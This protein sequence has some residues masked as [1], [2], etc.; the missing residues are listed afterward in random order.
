MVN[1]PLFCI[2]TPSPF[3]SVS[4]LNRSMI[5]S[6]DHCEHIGF[7]D[8]G[9]WE[10]PQWPPFTRCHSRHLDPEWITSR[11]SAMEHMNV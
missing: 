10:R 9:H 3:G 2:T 8:V 6:P 5:E 1:P 11:T 7:D 4:F